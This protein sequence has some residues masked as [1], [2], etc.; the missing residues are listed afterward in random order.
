MQVV[1]DVWASIGRLPI[2]VVVWV[3]F[4]LVPVNVASVMYWAE[5][6]GGL[7]FILAVG[8]MLPNVFMIFIQGGVTKAMAIPH[9]LLWTP[10]VFVI[11]Y[12]LLTADISDSF[13]TFLWVLLVV[14]II[15]LGFDYNDAA[16]WFRGERWVA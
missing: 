3:S 7:I 14:E 13:T 8:G 5:P 12:V 16:A 6:Y 10:L 9:V 11:L 4:V 1:G 2:W 15:S